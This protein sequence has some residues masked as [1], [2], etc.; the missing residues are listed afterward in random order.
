MFCVPNICKIG[1]LFSYF[2]CSHAI[3]LISEAQEAMAGAYGWT[4]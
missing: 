2:K 4:D 1:V 3:F